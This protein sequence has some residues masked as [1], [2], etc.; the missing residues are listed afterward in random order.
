MTEVNWRRL[1]FERSVYNI[2]EIILSLKR[3]KSF[4]F[5]SML[6]DGG[7]YRRKEGRNK[8]TKTRKKF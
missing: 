6:E 1:G 4:V 8:R 3:I 2:I 5:S 7:D